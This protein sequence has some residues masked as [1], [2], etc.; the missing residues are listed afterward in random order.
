VLPRSAA[1][2]LAVLAILFVPTAL[3]SQGIRGSVRNASGSPIATATVSVLNFSRSVTTNAD[4][5]FA[6]DIAAGS[7]TLVVRAAGYAQAIVPAT[8]GEADAPRVDVVLRAEGQALPQVVVTADRREGSLITAPAAVTTLD[9]TEV[10]NSRTWGLEGLSGRI[11][12]YLYQELGGPFQQIQSIRGIQVFSENPA[13]ATYVDGVNAL[14]ILG[15][16]FSLT[17]IE[18]IEVLRGPQGTQ[19]GRTA[20]GGVVNITTRRPTN[21]TEQFAEFTSGN[22]G[23]QRATLGFKAPLL[24]DRLFL[25]VTGLSERRDGFLTNDTTG[26]AGALPSAAGARIGTENRLY[27][28]MRLQWL[29]SDRVR[30]ALDLKAQENASDRSGFFVGAV[31]ET[32]ARTNPDRL[33]LGRVGTHDH[34]VFNGAL[35]VDVFG[36]PVKVTSVTSYQRIGFRY[37]DIESGGVYSSY[38]GGR[39]GA[40]TP[41]QEVWSQEFRASGGERG[42]RL[43][44]VAGVYGFDQVGYEPTTN[45]GFLLN[46]ATDTWAIFR[47]KSDNAGIAV[48]GQATLA[49]GN[50]YELTAGLRRDDERREATFNGFGDAVYVAGVETVTVP[51]TTVSGRYGAWTPKLAISKEFSASSSVYASYTR[52]FRAGGVNAQRLPAGVSQTFNPE[53][54]DNFEIGAK[55]RLLNDRVFLSATAFRVDWTDLQFFSV[56]GPST[57]ARAN[58]GDARSQGLELEASALPL[59]DLRIDAAAGLNSTEYIDFTYSRLAPDF[60]TVINTDVSGNRLANA[61]SRTLYLATEYTPELTATSRLLVRGE[62]RQIGDFFTDI[63]N[64]LAQDTFTLL[65]VRVALQLPRTEVALWVQNAT[66]ERY[67]DFGSP[68]TSFNRRSRISAPRTFGLTLSTRF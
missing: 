53:Y 54:S 51:D 68:D 59:A 27:G 46:P 41:P 8:A 31:S 37:T 35:S 25:A 13:V 23:L 56:V 36:G 7:Y 5:A 12:N 63:Q 9:A 50:G 42:D 65:N 2:A 6:I 49:L 22:L 38:F 24:A 45:L 15:N 55:T 64:D 52:G 39:L 48:Y 28:A 43:R 57:V 44:W 40:A 19:Y 16:G 3:H 32:A 17:D 60:V 34:D 4:G 29:A 66:D 21:R 26:V 14:D 67:L 1:A 62:L 11:P 20:M 58:V 33:N 30:A 10:R 61:P 18:S 47:N